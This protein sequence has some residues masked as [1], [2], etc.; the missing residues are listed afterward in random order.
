MAKTFLAKFNRAERDDVTHAVRVAIKFTY[1]GDAKAYL[2]ATGDAYADAHLGQAEVIDLV[3]QNVKDFAGALAAGFRAGRFE[4]PQ[5]PA[6]VNSFPGAAVIDAAD[7]HGRDGDGHLCVV[8]AA[9]APA[10]AALRAMGTL[11]GHPELQIV[12]RWQCGGRDHEGR[13]LIF[14]RVHTP[15][16]DV[17]AEV[18]LGLGRNKH[19]LS[20]T[21]E[22][23]G[24]GLGC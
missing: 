5:W 18:G 23:S 12:G 21:F 14:G 8:L 3:V 7:K 20:V 22:P 11:L 4:Y 17:L 2:Q 1:A 15:G 16:P 6:T 10:S 13:N 24:I 19:V 9:D